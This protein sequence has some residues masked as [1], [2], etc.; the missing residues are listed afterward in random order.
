MRPMSKTPGKT[1]RRTPARKP[2]ANKLKDPVEVYCRIKPLGE[3]EEESCVK[4]IDNDSKLLQLTAP[5]FSQAFK[6]G[7]RIET[8]HTFKH[9]Y[10]ENT[11]QKHLFDQVALPLVDDVLHGKNGLIFAYGITGSGKT[12]TMTG[13]PSDSGLLPRCLD[14]IFNSIA[15]YQT[16]TFIFKPD[17]NNGWEVQTED[18]AKLDREMKH[19]EA[20][21]QAAATPSR[22]NGNISPEF[23]DAIRIPEERR[24]DNID[25][26]NGYAVFV[27][28]IEIYNNFV[29][30]LLDESPV[31]PICPKPPVSKNLRE[32]G[33]HNMYISG[34][35]E[36]EVKTTEE[37]YGVFLKGQKGRRVA[38]TVLNQESSR[39]HSVFAIKV[40]QAPLDPDGEQILQDC[41]Q[42]AVSTLSL[43]DLAGS[44]RTKRTNAGGD[45]LREAGNINS[46]LMALRTCIE[47]L[48]E[49]Q[50]NY[51]N[52]V[53]PKIVPYRDSK[54][55]HLFKNFFDG[56]GKVRMVVC[57]NQSAEEYDESIHVMKFAELTQEVVVARPSSIKFETGLTPGRRRAHQM[58]R[59]ALAKVEET[60]GEVEKVAPAKPIHTMGTPFPPLLLSSADDSITLVT[61]L[62]Y[63]QERM[64][65]RQTLA[66]DLAR[67]QGIFRAQLQDFEKENGNT[68]SVINQLKSTVDEKDRE[69]QRLERRLKA[70]LHKNEMLQKT[71]AMY[72]QDKKELQYDLDDQKKRADKEKQ[73][74]LKLKTALKGA[75]SQEKDKWE[76][77]CNKRVKDKELE[78]ENKVWQQEEK[79]RQL[80]DIVQNMKSDGPVTRAQASNI[81]K[82]DQRPATRSQIRQRAKSPPPVA[83]KP[84]IRAKQHRRSKSSDCWIEHKPPC[85]LDTDTILQPFMK[86]KKTVSRPDQKDF[87]TTN[88]TNYCLVDQEEDSSGEIATKIIKGDV[89]KTAGGGHS[90]QFTAI[91]TLKERLQGNMETSPD[92]KRRASEDIDDSESSWT[93]TETRCTYGIEGKPGQDPAVTHTLPKRKRT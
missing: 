63:L 65:R 69:I 25:E 55:T 42:V 44:E 90:I 48:R 11:T 3:N 52:G 74:K 87:K 64:R 57:L 49:N 2:S 91:E 56:E 47:I 82:A 86:N 23:S 39:S 15:E 31:D 76:K 62:Q 46:S 27:S 16:D 6:S 77:E 5:K 35:T 22:R 1:P 26:D 84:P 60:G 18:E 10:D 73:E 72:E 9:V 88:A 51:E 45:R 7:H 71:A 33:S 24:I 53:S 8:Q 20:L 19:K 12:H 85:H 80:K 67:K 70:A 38:Q 4:I 36:I 81:A 93:D 59:E 40:V 92:R 30:D 17:K 54:L 13:T 34:V 66:D 79:L 21:L 89:Y 78:M 37:A 28:Y 50:S 14:V 83:R 58:F 41:D 32:D 68:G 29:Y 61:L 75:I 43:C